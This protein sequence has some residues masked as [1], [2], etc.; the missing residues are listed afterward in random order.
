[1]T[2]LASRRAFLGYLAASPVFTLV[3]RAYAQLAGIGE[4]E[5]A[6]RALELV[7][8]GPG[9]SPEDRQR[10]LVFEAKLL[11]EMGLLEAAIH[12]YERF[13]RDYPESPTSAIVQGRLAKLRA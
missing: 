10:A 5:V 7:A 1:M 13:L 4:R 3:S 11:V 9:I 6:A 12:V 2:V 8:G